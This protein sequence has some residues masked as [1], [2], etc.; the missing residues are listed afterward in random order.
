MVKDGGFREDLWQRLS[1][2]PLRIPPLR[3]RLEDIIFY[4]NYYLEECGDEGV[5]YSISNDGV[6]ALLAYSWPGN[7]RELKGVIQRFIVLSSKTVL[8]AVEFKIALEMGELPTSQTTAT[9]KIET[10]ENNVKKDE[11][12]KAITA[13]NGNK[14]QAAA[15]LGMKIRTLH[16]WVK[17]FEIDSLFS[18]INTS[19]P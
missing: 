10:I 4:A 18:T 3:E 11:L 7:I 8:D 12:I 17:K 19:K 1:T 5:Q 14:T 16:R 15:E 9:T 13:C 6:Q 2:F